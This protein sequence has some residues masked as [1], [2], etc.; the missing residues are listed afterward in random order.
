MMPGSGVAPALRPAAGPGKETDR[1]EHSDTACSFWAF[2][3]GFQLLQAGAA[4]GQ[5]EQRDWEPVT[6]ERLLNPAGRRLDD[7]RRTY[8]VT[9]FSPL[10]QINRETVGDLRLVWAYSMRDGSAGCRR[11]SSPTG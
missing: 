4:L 9:G 1:C 11:R 8:D 3:A 2:L 6:D 7:F 5:P 10:E